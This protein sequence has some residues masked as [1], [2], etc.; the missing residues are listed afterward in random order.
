MKLINTS[1][2]QLAVFTARNFVKVNNPV[3]VMPDVTDV[4]GKVTTV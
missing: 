1:R 2:I 4:R 3:E